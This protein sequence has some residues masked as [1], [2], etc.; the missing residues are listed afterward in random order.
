MLEHLSIFEDGGKY[1]AV[2]VRN[3]LERTLIEELL[4]FAGNLCNHDCVR[5]HRL[6]DIE[7]RRR[8][9]HQRFGIG[10]KAVKMSLLQRADRQ[11]RI[12]FL[13]KRSVGPR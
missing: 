8:H 3:K 5:K 7:E 12:E 13:G 6:K 11:R 9:L 1:L 10:E 4:N 2:L